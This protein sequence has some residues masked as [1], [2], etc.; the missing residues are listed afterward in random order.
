MASLYVGRQLPELV[1]V[2]SC[3]RGERR[4]AI[5]GY[6]GPLEVWDRQFTPAWKRLIDAAPHPISQFNAAEC[7][8]RW[9]EFS[10]KNGWT[11]EEACAY[12][13]RAVHTLCNTDLAFPLFGFGCA[14]IIPRTN[15]EGDAK[16]WDQLGLIY[17]FSAILVNVLKCCQYRWPDVTEVQFVH[18]QQPDINPELQAAFGEARKG[19][20]D[21]VPFH[22][23]HL[24]FEDSRVVV[25][26]QA[27]DIL[28]NETRLD[29]IKRLEGKARSRAL[30]C[31]TMCR[32]HAGFFVNNEALDDVAA[33]GLMP[34]I[35]Y[36]SESAEFALPWIDHSR[37]LKPSPILPDDEE[38]RAS[39]DAYQGSGTV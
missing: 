36:Q 13:I 16:A 25:P 29:L 28:A 11:K 20:I 9:K 12:G 2:L 14:T 38:V 31:M 32:P 10:Q 33:H 19:I 7:K 26:L 17:C 30:H 1:M 21:D 5:A 4:N 18:H 37:V 15:D 35:L 34:P 39:F 22:I 8:N 27:A 24:M 3:S 6:L 23:G